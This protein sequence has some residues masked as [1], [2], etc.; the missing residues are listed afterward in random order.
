MGVTRKA[1]LELG[2]RPLLA[3][4]VERLQAHVEPLLLSCESD[5]NAFEDFGLKI[6]PDLLPRFRG[7]LAG[8]CSALQLLV[9][10]GHEGALVLCPCDAP[11]IPSNLV[12]VLMDSRGAYKKPLVVS[13]QGEWQPTFSLW[14][15]RHLPL[16][17]EA[18]FNKG[19][20]GLKYVLAVMSATVVEWP[21]S[22][23]SP[24]F[25]IN[26]PL[27]LESAS[28]WLDRKQA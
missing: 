13:Y 27:D 18:V 24:F 7:P 19:K 16:I 11:F 15:T 23:P 1:L 6:V 12:E 20:G 9:E 5:T 26:T 25:N 17:R 10:Q 14:H 22:D 3:R 28:L 21:R 4:V 2:G 8:L